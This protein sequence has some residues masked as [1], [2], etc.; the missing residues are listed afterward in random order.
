[1]IINDDNDNGNSPYSPSDSEELKL[2]LRIFPNATHT[3]FME[4]NKD[5]SGERDLFCLR[6]SHFTSLSDACPA[7]SRDSD[8]LVC[9]VSQNSFQ[10]YL[11]QMIIS[12]WDVISYQQHIRHQHFI[13]PLRGSNLRQRIHLGDMTDTSGYDGSHYYIFI[14]ISII[15][16]FHFINSLF[17]I[18]LHLIPYTIPNSLFYSQFRANRLSKTTEQAWLLFSGS[19]SL[20]AHC[21]LSTTPWRFLIQ[22]ILFPSISAWMIMRW[23]WVKAMGQLLCITHVWI[24][25]IL[26]LTILLSLFQ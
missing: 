3:I 5:N 25:S 11:Y 16:T 7:L 21:S 15:I 10:F 2:R 17:Y 23:E 14:I 22:I 1:M 26:G 6:V 24:K 4:W 13:S 20:S 19:F 8:Y 18:A 12:L 9:T